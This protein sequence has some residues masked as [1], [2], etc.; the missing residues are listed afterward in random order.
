MLSD[1][2]HKFLFSM[3]FV[4]NGDCFLHEGLV[5]VYFIHLKSQFFCYL[6]MTAQEIM[7]G[8]KKCNIYISSQI[9]NDQFF[10]EHLSVGFFHIKLHKS[11]KVI[12]RAMQLLIK[13]NIF[14][15]KGKEQISQVK[16]SWSIYW[17]NMLHSYK[18]GHNGAGREIGRKKSCH[19]HTALTDLSKVAKNFIKGWNCSAASW[20][21]WK[22]EK[23][24]MWEVCMNHMIPLSCLIWP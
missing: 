8:Q 24:R 7:S 3:R 10:C 12:N 1:K 19:V 23:R 18:G 16:M 2:S 4:W 13:T 5:E 20:K 6:K 22:S 9:N 17:L 21:A 14:R 15:V 11:I